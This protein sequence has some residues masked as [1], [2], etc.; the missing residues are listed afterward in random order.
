M[1]T[2]I[3]KNENRVYMIQYAK[4]QPQAAL[5][6]SRRGAVYKYHML[7]ALC[8]PRVPA[9]R[10]AGDTSTHTRRTG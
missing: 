7:A 5:I 10:T 8:M 6:V 3:Q 4:L 2:K 9:P 1:L